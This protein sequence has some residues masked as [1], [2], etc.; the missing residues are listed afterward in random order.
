MT[1]HLLGDFQKIMHFQ[2]LRPFS[3]WGI[4]LLQCPLIT[5]EYRSHWESVKSLSLSQRAP[6]LISWQMTPCFTRAYCLSLQIVLPCVPRWLQGL[7]EKSQ[8]SLYA[9]YSCGVPL[10]LTG[11]QNE[12]DGASLSGP[13]LWNEGSIWAKART[14]PLLKPPKGTRWELKRWGCWI[15]T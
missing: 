1:T 3:I 6:C 11:F 4:E 5:K 14:T 2:W 7:G 12:W 8:G 15:M 9:L 10:V 13:L